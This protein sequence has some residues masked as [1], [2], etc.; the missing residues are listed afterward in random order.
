MSIVQFTSF[1]EYIKELFSIDPSI[2]M[3]I[4]NDN[5]ILYSF[6]GNGLNDI[7]AFRSVIIK[8]EDSINKKREIDDEIV[9]I[10]KDGKKFVRNLVN[11]VDYDEII[12]IRLSFNDNDSYANYMH[13]SNSKLKL[14]EISGDPG[15]VSKQ[16]SKK[17]IEF[18]TNKTNALF[19]FTISEM[20]FNKIRRMSLIETTNDVL[21]INVDNNEL[22]MGETKWDLKI[23]EVDKPNLNIS[24]PK[25]YFNTLKFKENTKIYVFENYIMISDENSD[26]M[27]VL[28]TSV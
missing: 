25:K 9:F 26:L 5:I 23:C 21:Y 13:I 12:K 19:N 24:F 17:D 28:E 11:F 8:T 3:K 10:I 7:H 1:I 14:K 15:V 16:I 6:V 2:V 18:L 4:N 22:L 20:D 27:I